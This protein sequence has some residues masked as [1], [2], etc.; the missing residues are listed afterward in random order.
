M[1]VR[2]AQVRDLHRLTEITITSLRDD[3]AFDYMW[4]RWRDFPEDNFVWWQMKLQ[5]WLHDPKTLF[6]VTVLDKNDD[7]EADQE[8]PRSEEAQDTIIAYC[9][10]ERWSRSPNGHHR[11]QR[12]T[13][14]KTGSIKQHFHN[15]I[16]SKHPFRLTCSN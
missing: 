6:L 14:L 15:I 10:W 3:P 2:P 12:R 16:D 11:W 13:M 4:S 9:I 8:K 7:A 5:G 1:Y